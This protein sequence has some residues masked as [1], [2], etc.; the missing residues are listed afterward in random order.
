ELLSGKAIEV[1]YHLGEPRTVA[2]IAERTGNYRNTVNR[3]LKPLLDRGIVGRDGSQYRINDE[4]QDVI[5]FVHALVRHSHRQTM[6]QVAGRHRLIWTG[7]H[8]FLVET[9]EPVEAERFHETGP[10][11]LQDHGIQI[12]ATEKRYYLY[13]GSGAGFG[14]EDLLCHLLLIDRSP[15]FLTYALLLITKEDLDEGAVRSTAERYGVTDLV[16]QLFT[17]LEQ[18]G[19]GGVTKFPSWQEFQDTAREYGVTV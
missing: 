3:E 16:D 12:L 5:Q 1:L 17:Y 14:P 2:E 10:R 9:S 6:K 15:R 19:D 8:S 4:F 13:D 11:R 18:E 7:L